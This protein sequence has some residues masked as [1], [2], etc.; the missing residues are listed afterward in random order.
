MAPNLSDSVPCCPSNAANSANNPAAF[1]FE[2]KSIVLSF[3]VEIIDPLLKIFAAR[4]S[5]YWQ[6]TVAGLAP[7]IIAYY[8]NIQNGGSADFNG[9]DLTSFGSVTKIVIP[10]FLSNFA[11]G[12]FIRGG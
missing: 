11:F 8:S 10:T 4:F 3:H 5:F 9:D 1:A 6:C 12:R 7:A 2:A